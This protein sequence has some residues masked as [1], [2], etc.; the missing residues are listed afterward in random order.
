MDAKNVGTGN[1]VATPPI[2]MKLPESLAGCIEYVEKFVEQNE[3]KLAESNP[4]EMAAECVEIAMKT[5]RLDNPQRVGTILRGSN[6]ASLDSEQPSG[7]YGFTILDGAREAINNRLYSCAL[8]KVFHLRGEPEHMA[9][10]APEGQFS[11]T[12]CAMKMR[13]IIEANEERVKALGP[14]ENWQW[15]NRAMNTARRFAEEALG[16]LGVDSDWKRLLEVYESDQ[17]LWGGESEGRHLHEQ[18]CK[19]LVERMAEVGLDEM[20]DLSTAIAED[21]AA[22]PQP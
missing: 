20:A 19:A 2:L 14:V 13:E 12:D 18:M 16:A 4:Y 21:E 15:N 6:G 9:A 10:A 11:V 5:L 8:D 3:W 1:I 7:A 22:A 17:T